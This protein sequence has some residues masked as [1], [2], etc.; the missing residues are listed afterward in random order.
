MVAFL[1]KYTSDDKI[2]V[3]TVKN[4]GWLLRQPA[5]AVSIITV[6]SDATFEVNYDGNDIQRY[7]VGETGSAILRVSLNYED[8][9][10]AIYH[11]HFA[12]VTLADRFAQRSRFTFADKR[13]RRW[14]SNYYGTGRGYS[15]PRTPTSI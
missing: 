7:I 15:V 11:I 12:D 5:A 2:T 3:R 6:I 8:N 14:D 9:S 1:R 10:S 4:L 13:Y